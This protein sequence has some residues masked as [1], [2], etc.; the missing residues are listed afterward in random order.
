M[1]A[2]DCEPPRNIA[3]GELPAACLLSAVTHLDAK[4]SLILYLFFLTLHVNCAAN[5]SSDTRSCSSGMTYKFT[6]VLCEAFQKG[7]ACFQNAN[8]LK[9]KQPNSQGFFEGN[10]HSTITTPQCASVRVHSWGRCGPIRV[11]NKS[12]FVPARLQRHFD[13]LLDYCK[14]LM[15]SQTCKE[16]LNKAS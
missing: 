12:K 3:L 16:V 10:T 4:R 6:Q 7:A 13:P 1:S 15:M 14:I 8:C 11:K 9:R 2:A 5:I